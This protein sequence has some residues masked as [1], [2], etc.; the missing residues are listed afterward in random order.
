MDEE[1][2]REHEH[3]QRAFPRF[4][5]GFSI[6][7]SLAFYFFHYLRKDL[8]ALLDQ[9]LVDDFLEEGLTE[10]VFPQLLLEFYT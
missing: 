1:C 6:W 7:F 8:N 9:V 4:P 10:L 5:S 2:W 3:D